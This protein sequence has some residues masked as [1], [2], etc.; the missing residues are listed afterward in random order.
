MGVAR[1]G[2][3]AGGFCWM[4]GAVDAELVFGNR[5]GFVMG[6]ERGVSLSSFCLPLRKSFLNLDPFS[7]SDI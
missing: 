5:A 6:V 4:G 7:S 2:A 1:T 3:T